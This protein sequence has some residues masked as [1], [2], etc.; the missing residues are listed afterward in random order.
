MGGI[1]WN[2]GLFCGMVLGRVV[3]HFVPLALGS[4]YTMNLGR[5]ESV[6]DSGDARRRRNVSGAE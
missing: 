3:C 6:E 1:S 2:S 5:K 4:A